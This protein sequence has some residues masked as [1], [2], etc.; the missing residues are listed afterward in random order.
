MIPAA[1]HQSFG[2]EIQLA[3]AEEGGQFHC[4]I[5]IREVNRW[6]FPYPVVTSQVR[7]MGYL[8]TPL[9]DAN[10]G[11]ES[12]SA[13]LETLARRRRALHGRI[14]LLDT[15]GGD[16]PVARYLRQ[17]A[18]RGNFSLTAYQTWDRGKLVRLEKPTYEMVHSSKARYN[19]R[20]QQRLLADEV[21][22]EVALV[23][24]TSDP[25]ALQDYVDLEASG[26]KAAQGVAM[27]T[28]PGEP[29]YF[30]DMCRRFADSGRLH[31]L[32]LMAGDK[33]LAMEIWIRG[34]VGLFMIKISYDERYKRFGPG[35]LLQTSAIRHFH[36]NTDAAW[37]DT[38]TSEGAE[39]LLRLYPGRRSVEMLSI[40]LTSSILDRAVVA[41]FVGLRP[42]HKYLFDLRHSKEEF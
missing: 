34:G 21:G 20:R 42:L 35:V 11:V 16:G 14:F 17:A 41:G 37:I 6:K 32:A 29:E 23:D 4:A 8:G 18:S 38:C 27:A 19:L 10:H 25:S 5:P 15:S 22:E 40:V 7:R 30:V 39:L 1:V 3:V 26:Y 36:E 2:A 13:V 31:V 9:V 12:I 33:T 24:R 28:V